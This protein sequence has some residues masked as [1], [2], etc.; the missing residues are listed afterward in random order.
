MAKTDHCVVRNQA[1]KGGEFS[2]RERHNER[3]NEE[4]G[5]GDIVKDRS[6]LNIHF[7]KCNGT[8]KQ[9]FECMVEDGTISLRGL[10][11]DPKVFDEFV[12]D[13]NTSY[14][15]R[16]GGYEYAKDFFT[17]AYKLA[18]KEV[19]GEQYIL[20]AVMHADERNK[21][22]T[23]RLGYDVFHYHLHVVYVPVVDKAVYYRKN[24]KN[25]ELAGTLKKTIKQVSHS[26]KWSRQTQIDENGKIIRNDKGK[27]ILVN[28]YSLLQ[29]RYYNHMKM[30]GYEDIERG[31]RGSTREH[32]NDLE[33][34]IQQE[35][36][37][38]NTLA[39]KLNNLSM[40]IKDKQQK[41]I[42]FNEQ[43]TAQE[44]HLSM[45]DKKIVVKNTIFRTFNDIESMAKQK[46][47]GKIE[48]TAK[49]WE[50]VSE[51]AKKGV[52]ANANIKDLQ[53]KIVSANKDAEIYKNRLELLKEDTKEYQKAKELAPVR[54]KNAINEI[55]RLGQEPSEPIKQIKQKNKDIER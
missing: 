50:Q 39:E 51:L 36:E 14:F 16:N 33:Y 3:K 1:Y 21:A 49:D 35:T 26:K 53:R 10:G 23:E 42:K 11:K 6:C 43:I 55:V 20:S 5:N 22:E 25:T 19:G 24:N 17:E 48:L 7:K 32:L 37:K 29:D 38:A 4:Y 27:A 15:E 52:V 54:T 41:A 45:L 31:K 8:Y 44:K 34:K 28:S 13:V 2:I 18:V 40:E 12:F 46:L 9:A 30:A 47:F